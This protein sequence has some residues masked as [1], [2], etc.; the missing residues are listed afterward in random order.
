MY[1]KGLE[2]NKLGR[3]DLRRVSVSPWMNACNMEEALDRH[4][5]EG[6]GVVRPEHNSGV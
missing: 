6:V 1:G 3:G 5:E 2:V 4:R